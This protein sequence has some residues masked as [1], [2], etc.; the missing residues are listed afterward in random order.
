MKTYFEVKIIQGVWYWQGKA[1]RLEI[2][3]HIYTGYLT[4]QHGRAVAKRQF[5]SFGQLGIH[6]VKKKKCICFPTSE[7]PWEINSRWC[8]YINVKDKTIKHLANNIEYLSSV[9]VGKNFLQ[10]KKA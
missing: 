7:S 2:D 8:T 5:F 6:K 4:E 3:P 1:N 9:R 10:H